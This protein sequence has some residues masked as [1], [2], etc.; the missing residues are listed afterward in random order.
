MVLT[1]PTRATVGRA[2]RRRL[3]V[4]E[5]VALAVI[6]VVGLWLRLAGMTS[7]GLWRDDAWVAMSSRVSMGTALRMG[8][9]APGFTMI[10]RAWILLD[11]GSSRWAQALPVALGVAGIVTMFC[12]SRYLGL[13][14]WLS[15]ATAAFVALSP[16]TI[17]YSTHAKQYSTDVVLACALLALGEAARRRR[18]ERRRLGALAVAS[19]AGLVISASVAVVI[20][21][22]WAMLLITSRRD[23]D[24]RVQVIT[25]GAITAVSCA[26]ALLF[27][28]H[29]STA[30]HLFWSSSTAS[31][32]PPRSTSSS[33]GSCRWRR[34]QS[35]G[36]RTLGCS[37]SGSG[38]RS[39]WSRWSV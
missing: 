23:R 29:L 22:V 37:P 8:A 9:T 35:S 18:P 1:A 31:S 26:L 38:S 12:L 34:R 15:L 28:A 5:G 21:G 33:R 27:Y 7:H 11:P 20:I 13:S 14:T 2:G 39:P 3:D 32:R 17:A 10:E 16:V 4:V 6:V 30:L 24:G 19:C 25:V 36:P